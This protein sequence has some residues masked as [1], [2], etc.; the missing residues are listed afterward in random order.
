MA[1][2]LPSEIDCRR[3]LADGGRLEGE[4]D[5]ARMERV[6][7]QF[8]MAGAVAVSLELRREDGALRLEG[9]FTAP[10]EARCQRCLAWMELELGGEFS[11]TVDEQDNNEEDEDT[12][13]AP[14]GKLGVAALIEDE[15]VLACPMIPLHAE[16]ECR[17]DDA[18]AVESRP[19]EDTH[20]PFAA[21]GEMLKSAR[22]R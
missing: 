14:A 22:E 3:L 10:L 12:I 19:Q 7:G 6:G 4:I 9:R 11:F 8:R 1:E 2:Q 21:L 15:I 13:I 18:V 16:R 5:A 20:R 17:G